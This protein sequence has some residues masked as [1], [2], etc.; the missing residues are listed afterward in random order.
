MENGEKR[1]AEAKKAFKGK[2]VIAVSILEDNLIKD[3]GSYISK[4]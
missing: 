3:L 4:L 1:F 2:N